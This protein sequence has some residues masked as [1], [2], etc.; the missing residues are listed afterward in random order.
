[1]TNHFLCPRL[2]YAFQLLGKRWNGLIISALMTGPKRFK[3]ISE[4]IPPMSDKMLAE[5]IRELESE[6]LIKR[7]VYPEKPVRIE[8]ELTEKGM[9]LKPAIKAIEEWAESWGESSCKD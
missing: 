4:F 9:S 6:K 8:Y 3:E 7:T 5:R 2:A 1:M